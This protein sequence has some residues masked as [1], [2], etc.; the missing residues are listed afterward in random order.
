MFEKLKANILFERLLKRPDIDKAYK[1]VGPEDSWYDTITK[2][3][4]SLAEIR[5]SI[6]EKLYG[7]LNST[8]SRGIVEELAKDREKT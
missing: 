1:M 4:N 3:H 5:Q 2:V 7:G 8:P 6:A